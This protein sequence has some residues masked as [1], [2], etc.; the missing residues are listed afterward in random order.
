MGSYSDERT[1]DKAPLDT[2]YLPSSLPLS[3]VCFVA[4]RKC[5]G[6]EWVSNPAG[7]GKINGPT[8]RGREAFGLDDT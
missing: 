4:C 5:V 1:R 8:W 3:R 2:A 6:N 7:V